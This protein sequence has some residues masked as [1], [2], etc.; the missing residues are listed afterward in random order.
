[1]KSCEGTEENIFLPNEGSLICSPGKSMKSKQKILNK[2]PLLITT[3]EYVLELAN[4]YHSGQVEAGTCLQKMIG[5]VPTGVILKDV[6]MEVHGGELSAVLGSKG[7]ALPM[8]IQYMW[9]ST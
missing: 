1:M 8:S 4:V 3:S 9:Y 2:W 6:S 7:T 5:N